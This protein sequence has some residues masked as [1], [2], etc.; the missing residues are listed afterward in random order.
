MPQLT[1]E[2]IDSGILDRFKISGEDLDEQH[3]INWA[4]NPEYRKQFEGQEDLFDP[5]T[6]RQAPGVAPERGFVGDFASLL[7]RGA[8]DLTRMGGYSLKTL[9]PDGGADI[10]ESIGDKMVGAV[11]HAEENWGIMRPDASEA[12]GEGFWSRGWKGGVRSSVP[13][14]APVLTGGLAGSAFGPVGTLV[15]A[16]VATLGLFGLGVYGEKLAEYEKAG[17]PEGEREMAA[18]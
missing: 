14:L 18:F 12:A 9:D 13:S 8:G 4:Y 17:I 6:E 1:Q 3:K 16:G 2:E 15:G 10:V 5:F 7:A 11:D